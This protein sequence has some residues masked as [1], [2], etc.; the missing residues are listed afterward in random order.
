M[1][2]VVCGPDSYR[3]LAR[4]K[5]LELAFRQRHGS[6]GLNIEK[7]GTGAEGVD[8]LLSGASTPSLFSPKR[9]LR[10]SGMIEACPKAK[11]PALVKLFSHAGDDLI[12][13]DFEEEKPSEKALTPFKET[14]KFLLNDYPLLT[15]QEFKKWLNHTAKSLGVSDDDA[16]EKLFR[17]CEGD[18][19][20]AVNELT[21]FAAGSNQK[22]WKKEVDT[23][24]F[25]LADRYLRQDQSRFDVLDEKDSN[26]ANIVMQQSLSFMRVRDQDTATITPFVVSK[27]KRMN[28]Q[29]IE[30]VWSSAF[31]SFLV[32]R[33]GL[34]DSEE[35]SLLLR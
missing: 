5:E 13:V 15:G 27:M 35:A 2:I 30:S 6:S 3:A 24:V 33:T 14:P 11:L 12:V 28:A 7:L 21:K 29:A 26:L 31:L 4:A 32:Q 8:A 1:L 22:D 18:T 9:F 16:V 19:W 34:G 20:F 23:S 10:I 17:A 25:E